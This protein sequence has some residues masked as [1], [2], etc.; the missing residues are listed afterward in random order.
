MR[1]KTIATRKRRW[2]GKAAFGLLLGAAVGAVSCSDD[3]LTG[4]PSWLGNS[5]YERLQE[6]GSYTTV[7]RLIDDLDQREVLGHTGS[8]TLFVASDSAYNEWYKGNDWGVR[9][10]EQLSEAQKKLLLNNSMINNA[11]LIELMSNVSGTP[12]VEGMAMRRE[13]AVSLY[14][15]IYIM[16][17][18][19]MPGT[20]GWAELK[21]KGKSVAILKDATT[22][23]M[24]H[25]LP[26]YMTYN[27]IT[28]EDLAILTNGQSTSANEAWVNGKKVVER[29][30][31]C[32]NGY[33]QKVDGVIESSPNMAE[34]IRQHKNM[35]RW[36]QLLDRFSAPYYN[37]EATRAYQRI[38][39]NE[40]SVYTLRYFSK[41][42]VG[43]RSLE[44]LP[45]NTTQAPAT[46]SFDPGWNHYM[47]A[48]T[49]GYDLHYD[50]G[51][52]IVPT[53]E[54]LEAWWDTDGRDLQDE[55]KEWDSIPDATLAKL[56]NVNML[57]VFSST[58]P[59]KFGTILN[60]AK[61]VLGITKA[62]VDSCFMGCNGVVYLVNRVFTPAEF[63]SVAYPALAHESTMNIIYWALSGADGAVSELN[64]L[65]YL[66][67][68]QSTYA[69]LLPSNEAMKNYIDPA[70]YGNM[71]G[72]S[73]EA[74][75]Q[76]EFQY[77]KTKSISNRVQ[78]SRY[79]TTVDADGN[80]TQ[81]LRLQQTVG[82][83][84]YRKMLADLVDQLIIVIP[85]QGAK[86]E[87]YVAQGYS[88]F[89]TK[90]GTLLRV[91]MGSNGNL[92]FEG[93]W[94]IE[95]NSKK[96]ETTEVFEK[97]NG[98]GRSYLLEQQMPL[99]SQKSLYMT[100]SEHPEY[101][102]F[103][104]VLNYGGLL[105]QKL[106]NKYNPANLRNGNWNMRLFDNYNYTVFVPSTD[107]ITSLQDQ[108]LLPSWSIM[109]RDFDDD[110][111]HKDPTGQITYEDRIDSLCYAMG[112]Y[113][114]F[115]D[116][117]DEAKEL[118]RNDVD[119]CLVNIMADFAR[120]H[121]MDRSVAIGMAPEVGMTGNSYESMKRNPLTGRFYPLVVD[122][123]QT[124]LTVTDAMGNTQ[125]VQRRE[126][127][128]NNIC[129]EYWFEG[130][131]NTARLFM[132]S[133]AVAHL[134]DKP[135]RYETM[136]P[137]RTVVEEYLKSK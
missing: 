53:N 1:Q 97:T 34:I 102:A 80:M 93:G 12:P 28:S 4:Q 86:L 37:A 71:Q 35:S 40:D 59:S 131:G 18:S 92:A 55:Y 113:D 119:T 56:I 103:Q 67:S 78:A 76:I 31:T 36:S 22:P 115:T 81:G 47:Y 38:Y 19:E 95:H 65:P 5:I 132:G 136:K 42:S 49:M 27:K 96:L 128:Y 33:V 83:T 3:V 64:F 123:D 14:D 50:A 6:D 54:A 52:M 90:G 9:S 117:S 21:G 101:A 23:P 94:Q 134:I 30:I 72:D 88:L 120:Y 111:E 60:D 41:R 135:L 104:K 105:S 48:N 108:Q 124:S 109:D 58:V 130:S 122:Y 70:S 84:V 45:D 121:V 106:N 17:A 68:M 137:W 85:Q 100:L 32:K 110:A 25:F 61:D 118:M 75:S 43:G 15:S 99:G 2:L 98:N 51:A 79:V 13:T 87:D 39:N 129:R 63:S 77:D 126:G 133:D 125:Q 20:Q 46:L 107:A 127:L 114:E 89:K 116:G 8:K 11:Y 24:I 10:Y 29:D 91:S 7:L 62:D 16:P 82:T 57:D 112:W 44:T 73:L 69:L 66:L 26:A 74:P